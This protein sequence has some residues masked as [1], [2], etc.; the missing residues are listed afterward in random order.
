MKKNLIVMSLSTLLLFQTSASAIDNFTL[1]TIDEKY[2]FELKIYEDMSQIESLL[3]GQFKYLEDP[4]CM[5]S[6]FTKLIPSMMIH[7]EKI[8]NIKLDVK[9]NGSSLEKILVTLN[10]QKLTI[11]EKSLSFQHITHGRVGCDHYYNRENLGGDRILCFGT[12]RKK[13]ELAMWEDSSQ[14]TISCNLN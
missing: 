7:G 9:I 11:S 5:V 10:M 1:D 4:N 6:E 13:I 3:T 12:K 8:K 14:K 2:K